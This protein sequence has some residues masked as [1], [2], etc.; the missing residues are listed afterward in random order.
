MLNRSTAGCWDD[1][2][3][4][5]SAEACKVLNGDDDCPRTSWLREL[6]ISK[7]T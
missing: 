4:K 3:K 6:E 5:Y 1:D 2:V 7:L